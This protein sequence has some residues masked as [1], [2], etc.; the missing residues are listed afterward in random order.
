MGE[1][2][3]NLVREYGILRAEQD[4]FAAESQRR[5]AQAAASGRFA[6]EIAPVT[7]P[8]K[9]GPTVVDKDEHPR[10]DTTAES[11]GLR[12]DGTFE[13]SWF[14]ETPDF[15]VDRAYLALVST[16]TRSVLPFPPEPTPAP[17]ADLDGDGYEACA[18]AAATC[19]CDDAA[20][21]VCP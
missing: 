11:L 1:T 8:G 12:D 9:K 10:P 3:E 17:C 21:A 6:D 5:A 16:Q 18:C 19:D 14:V 13:N 2:A 7:V 20:Q 15:N 4:A